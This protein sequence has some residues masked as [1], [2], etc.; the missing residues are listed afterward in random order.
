MKATRRLSLEGYFLFDNSNFRILEKKV[1]IWL[2]FD[3]EEC[4]IDTYS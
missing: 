2:L 3:A 4:K 1:I